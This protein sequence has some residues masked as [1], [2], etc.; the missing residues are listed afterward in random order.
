MCIFKFFQKLALTLITVSAL[1]AIDVHVEHSGALGFTNRMPLTNQRM[2]RYQPFTL[3][4]VYSS[5]V[6]HEIKVF[7]DVGSNPIVHSNVK[8]PG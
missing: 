3:G 4:D 8:K 6:E 1:V 7:A 2:F 5:E